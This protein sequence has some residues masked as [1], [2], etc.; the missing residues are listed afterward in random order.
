VGGLEQDLFQRADRHRRRLDDREGD[1]VDPTTKE[2][3][4]SDYQRH[5]TPAREGARAAREILAAFP[6]K[7]HPPLAEDFRIF[8]TG[9]GGSAARPSQTGAKFVQEV[10]AVTLAVE[11]STPTSAA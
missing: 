9:S 4:W 1:V 6:D 8:M 3:L 10:N 7:K 11:H 5:H 2:I